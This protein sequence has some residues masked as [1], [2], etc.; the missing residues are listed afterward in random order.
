MQ[1]EGIVK[2]KFADAIVPFLVEL[3]KHFTVYEIEQIAQLSSSYAMRLYEFFMQY[4]DKQTGKGWLDISLEDLRFRFGLLPTE[5]ER[6]SDFKK[7]VLDYSINEINDKTD[8]TA[9]YEQRKKGRVIVGFRFDFTKKQRQQPEKIQET[10]KT[11]PEPDLFA[12]F[13]DVERKAIQ[14]R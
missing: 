1:N 9:T 11:T 6:M 4:L 8:L 12:D 3:E 5:Y 2:F 7:R 10:P 13:S 14:S